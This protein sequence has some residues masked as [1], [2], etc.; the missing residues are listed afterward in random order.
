MAK[1]D[2]QAKVG[3]GDESS[4]IV[5]VKADPG[6]NLAGAVK[7]YG[8]E[9][10]Y[11]NYLASFKIDVQDI[12]RRGIRADQ[13]EKAIQKAVDE[14]KPGVRKRGRSKAEKMADEFGSLSAEEKKALL[15]TLTA[16]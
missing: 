4:P 13:D 12:I 7:L 16:A 5:T 8:E 11:S 9:V 6:D 3:K 10:V 14:W 15:A 2:I 1:I